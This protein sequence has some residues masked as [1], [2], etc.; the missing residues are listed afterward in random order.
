MYKSIV[1]ISD[2]C[3][4]KSLPPL[5]VSAQMFLGSTVCPAH[6]F[7]AQFLSICTCSPR[8]PPHPISIWITEPLRKSKGFSLD[9]SKL[10]KG[11][12]C[13]WKSYDPLSKT[14]KKAI[15]DSDQYIIFRGKIARRWL[16]LCVFIISSSSVFKGA[17]VLNYFNAILIADQGGNLFS[18]TL[19]YILLVS[20]STPLRPSFLSWNQSNW[21]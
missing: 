3:Q 1:Q 15:C 17:S 14:N 12:L 5:C 16:A 19:S 8:L 18:P 4:N 6:I 20:P 11:W 9:D 7:A 21:K 10:E 13:F 2:H